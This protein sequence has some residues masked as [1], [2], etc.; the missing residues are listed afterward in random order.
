M[1]IRIEWQ[2]AANDYDL[3]LRKDGAPVDESAQGFT[4]FEEVML[5]QPANGTYQVFAHA[6]ATVPATP[7]A[8]RATLQPAAPPLVVRPGTYQRDPDGK[9]GPQMFQF[10]SDLRLIGADNGQTGRNVEPEIAIN[11]FG[12][13]YVTAIQGV[14]A[15]TDAWRSRD[16]GESFTYLGQPDGTQRVQAGRAGAGGGDTDVSVGS[17]FVLLDVPGVGRVSSTGRVYVSSLWLGSSTMATS[18]NEG[19]LFTVSQLPV[20]IH[21]RQWNV[22]AGTSRVWA[23]ARQLGALLVGTTSIFMVQS[24]DGGLT[25]PRGAFVTL[26]FTEQEKERLQGPLA[27]HPGPG[28]GDPP[29]SDVYNVYSGRAR[30]ELFLVRCPAPCTLPLLVVDAQNRIL[31]TAPRPFE[32]RRIFKAPPGMSVDNVFPVVAVDAAGGVHVAF[33]DKRRIFLMSSRDRGQTWLP[34]VQV[35]NPADPETATALFPWI[36]AG[37]SGRVGVMWYGT[38]REGDADSE[39]QFAG[40][41]WKLFYALTPD[42]LADSPLFQYVVASGT[43]AGTEAQGRGVVHVGSICTRGLSCN[44]DTP[45][46]N[47]NLAEYSS[48]TGDAS[49][50]ANIVFAADIATPNGQARTHFTKQ[51]GGPTALLRPIVSG[52]GF[53]DRSSSE[54]H[55]GF[56][57]QGDPGGP[58]TGH[59]AYFE[60][61]RDLMLKA[62]A[63]TSVQVA[64]SEV[65]FAGT[66]T[67]QLGTATSTVTFTVVAADNGE[68]GGGNDRFSIA[69]SNG[70]RAS[71]VLDGGNIQQH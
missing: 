38:S 64:G 11:P 8:G 10:T 35:N 36:F 27:A 25:Y 9:F 26:L 16:G 32:I 59:L 12:T 68:P 14:P 48:L 60:R 28:R 52:G 65:T 58:W 47:R 63:I 30:D 20:P 54:K 50:Q 39:A 57:V 56:Q 18:L 62:A 66:G 17:P 43:T 23:T 37:D 44:L 69:L 13:I 7:Y 70:Y 49:G 15:G 61:G 42:A 40:A 51:V 53:F 41:E 1:F 45:P 5:R 21:D 55:F 29:N 31:P 34:P 4:T 33:S 2:N 71:G 6:F 22:S 19:D 3:F 46:G 67:L 24:D